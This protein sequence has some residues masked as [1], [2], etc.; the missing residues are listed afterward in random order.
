MWAVAMAEM[1]SDET[2][3]T[4]LVSVFTLFIPEGSENLTISVAQRKL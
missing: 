3:F 4:D 1:A 2:V